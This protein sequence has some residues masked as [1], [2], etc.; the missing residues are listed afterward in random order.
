M[1]S[2]GLQSINGMVRVQHQSPLPGLLGARPGCSTCE[3]PVLIIAV[4]DV[5]SGGL[6]GVSRPR[7]CPGCA[8][9]LRPW[10]YARPRAIRQADGA[11]LL[12][13]PRRMRCAGC[14]VTHV[15]LP[16]ARVPRRADAAEVIGSALLAKAA[17]RGHRTIAAELGVPAGTVRGSAAA[18]PSL[19]RSLCKRSPCWITARL[20]CRTR[21]WS[22]GLFRSP[23]SAAGEGLPPLVGVHVVRPRCAAGA[24]RGHLRRGGSDR[25]GRRK[26]H[27]WSWAQAR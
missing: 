25:L 18:G 8:G 9:R 13:R 15:V 21:W 12:V 5:T 10:G 24:P 16:A 3:E 14:R 2:A 6:A 19:S 11:R 20:L 27:V 4:H 22:M 17:G 26:G 7:S 23:G 1:L